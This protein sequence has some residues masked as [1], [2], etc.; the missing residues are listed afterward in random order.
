MPHGQLP[1]KLSR[2]QVGIDPGRAMESLQ[3]WGFNLFRSETNGVEAR[4]LA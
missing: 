1:R 2:G 3:T 4:R